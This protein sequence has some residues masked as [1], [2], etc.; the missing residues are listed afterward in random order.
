MG[1]GVFQL[2]I[3]DDDPLIHQSFRL[4]LPKHW[5]P[6]SATSIQEIPE[7][8]NFHAAF[9]DM[10][11]TKDEPDGLKAIAALIRGRPTLDI[12]AMSGDVRRDL[13]EA[14][15]RAGAQR[16]LA[17][18]LQSE[19]ILLIL[20]K[21][22]ALW[23]LRQGALRREAGTKWIGSSSASQNVLKKVATLK[24]EASPILIEGE[25][26]C[27]K[28]VVARLLV[29][30]EDGERP[31]VPVNVAALP[32]NLFESELFGHVR[33]AFSGADRDKVGLIEAADGGDLF[34]DEIE[35][36]PLSQQVKLLR[37]LESGEIRRVG[38]QQSTQVRCRVIAAGNR[39]LEAMI[40]DGTFREDLY[41][42][43]AGQRIELPP[44]RTRTSDIGELANY[45]LEAERPR[46][47]KTVTV[48][49]IAALEQ[50]SWPGNIRELKR[51]C[52]RLSL[53]SPLPLIRAEDVQDCL[54]GATPTQAQALDLARGLAALVE[55]YEKMIL[56]KALEKEKDVEKTASLLGISRSNLYKKLKDHGLEP[57]G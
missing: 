43:L 54:R 11:L 41:Y 56:Q 57:L 20:T 1:S 53:A 13:M 49:G 8:R 38:S 29:E 12:V 45:F 30:Q 37:F 25:S 23:D 7:T 36:F 47:N 48:D 5:R 39:P 18:P 6:V 10:H 21:L 32:E 31:F 52:E 17:K 9:V 55:D 19:E 44:L 26:G 15:L 46:R 2:L 28:E 4:C 14:A 50:H 27:G 34:L 16:F 24:G 3:V 33:G 35:A 22:E 51:V 42:R 40:R